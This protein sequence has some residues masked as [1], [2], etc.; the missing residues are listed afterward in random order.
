MFQVNLGKIFS[1]LI[2]LLL[3]CG[4]HAPV[5]AGQVLIEADGIRLT[6]QEVVAEL[7]HLPRDVQNGILFR[8]ENFISLI[9]NLFVR[10]ILVQQMTHDDVIQDSLFKSQLQLA[11][12]KVSSDLYLKWLDERNTPNAAELDK[13]AREIYKVE[14]KRFIEQAS[15][16]ASHILLKPGTGSKNVANDLLDKLRGGAD[17]EVLAKEYS[18]DPGSA[19]KGGDLGVFAQGRMVK[20]FDEAVFSSEEGALIGPIE[21]QFGLH[22]IKVVTMI[23]AERKSYDQVKADLYR[24][25][26][27]KAQ[28]D[29]RQLLLREIMARVKMNM[30][31]IDLYIEEQRSKN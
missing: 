15:A 17:F 27:S 11:K 24:E 12:E 14:G 22:I 6:G 1:I 18:S 30:P 31:A 2:L 25:I 28:A 29:A 7:Q 23:P 20:A 8:K 9:S 10:R 5:Q 16:R 19:Q 3:L 4:G 26:A 13:R 21:T